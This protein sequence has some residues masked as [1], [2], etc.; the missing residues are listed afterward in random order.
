MYIYMYIYI[1]ICIY[2]LP[3]YSLVLPP[4][5]CPP[6][7]APLF[8]CGALLGVLVKNIPDACATSA[9]SGLCRAIGP[10]TF[11]HSS[12]INLWNRNRQ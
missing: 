8:P 12:Q 5:W 3:P 4:L 2:I 11:L 1:Y 10:W 9:E 7:G 6:C